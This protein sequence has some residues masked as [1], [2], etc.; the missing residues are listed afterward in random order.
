MQQA[1]NDTL[2]NGLFSTEGR[3]FSTQSVSFIAGQYVY[4]YLYYSILW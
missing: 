4:K 1:H 3:S 2:L